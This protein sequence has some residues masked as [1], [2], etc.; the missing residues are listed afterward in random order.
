MQVV[1][2]RRDQFNFVLLSMQL[3]RRRTNF[4]SCPVTSTHYGFS[5][6]FLVWC[7]FDCCILCYHFM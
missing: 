3:D 4:I 7:Y 5:Y 2:I 1:E 6:V